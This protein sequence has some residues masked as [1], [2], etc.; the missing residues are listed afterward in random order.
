MTE[1]VPEGFWTNPPFDAFSPDERVALLE[2]GEIVSFDD[3]D[4]IYE[5]HTTSA[6]AYVLLDGGV[7]L[8]DPLMESVGGS[9]PT[10]FDK[11]GTLFSRGSLLEPFEHRHRCR[12]RGETRL[13]LIPRDVFLARFGTGASFATRL[14]DYLVRRTSHE[15]RALNAA[16]H[17]FLSE[18]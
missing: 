2:S 13:L 18:R 8:G 6:G 14:L 12:A 3:G 16:V 5:P 1:A 10:V 11:P 7:E 17:S 4:I 9:S 15:V